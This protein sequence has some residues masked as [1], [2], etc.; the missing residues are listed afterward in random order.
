MP[1]PRLSQLKRLINIAHND[2]SDSNLIKVWNYYERFNVGCN[3]S[4]VVDNFHESY[5]IY[6]LQ[7]ACDVSNGEMRRTDYYWDYHGD[8]PGQYK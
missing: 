4:F 6:V 8:T 2:M 5:Q 3:H 1:N 7:E